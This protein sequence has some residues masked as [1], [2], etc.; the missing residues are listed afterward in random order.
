MHR[1]KGPKSLLAT[2]VA[3]TA[4]L[5]VM[6]APTSAITKGGVVDTNND[7]PYVGLMVAYV[8]GVPSWR[9]SGTLVSPKLFITAGHCTDGADHVEIWFDVDLT[10]AALHNYPTEGDASGT[11]YTHPD[12]DPNAFYTH[13]LG[14]VVL[15][16][17]G[18]VTADGT[19]ATLLGQ[20]DAGLLDGL[21]V[22]TSFITVGYGLQSS[23]P[24][25]PASVNNTQAE[26]IRMIATPKLMQYVGDFAIHLSNNSKTGGTCFGDSGGPTFYNGLLVAVTSFGYTSTCA[27]RAGVYRLDTADD[28]NWLYS[29][30]FAKYL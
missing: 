3:I 16:G 12:Y 18:Y 24:A 20:D 27:G 11:P 14:V 21:A 17:K 30:Q 23:Y 26:R 8:D 9:C 4:L 28:L 29:R 2:L 15:D 13:D 7:Y 25:G 22:G 1:S 5:M 10:D 19:Y 6:V